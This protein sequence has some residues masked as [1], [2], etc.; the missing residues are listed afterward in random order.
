MDFEKRIQ[1]IYDSCRTTEQIEAAFGQLQAELESDIN[2]RIQK[3][4][5]LLLDN[6]DEDIHDL[7]KLQLDQAEQRLD[8]ISRWFWAVTRHQLKNTAEFD[9]SNHSFLLQ[10]NVVQETPTGQYQLIRRGQHQ[11]DALSNAHIYR[12]THPLGEWVLTSAKNQATPPAHITF[13][14]T[15]HGAKITVLES[16]LGKTGTLKCQRYSIEALER[17]E[18][19]LLFA[20]E[21]HEG[22]P[23]PVET[24]QKLMQLPAVTC[25][26]E[27]VQETPAIEQ[28]LTASQHELTKMVNSRNLAFFEE[29]VNKL[30]HWADDLKFGLE[31]S[32]KETDKEIKEVR[33]NAKI[34]PTLEEKLAWQKQ[35]RD[36]ERAR[37]K[38]RKE[39]FDR[40]DEVDE[41]REALIEQLEGKLN[42]TVQ[43]E[44]LFTIRWSLN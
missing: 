44:D 39:L 3:T 24:A 8:K 37:N 38:Q 6:F 20:A 13:N 31:Q 11:N 30:D 34:A 25:R 21:T 33:R 23:I 14:Y 22:K 19:H 32:I 15:A 2:A 9:D 16:L 12:L 26:P 10:Q 5:Q 41:R 42:Q 27:A 17:T 4:Q 1:T 40:Q 18:D 28:T 7:L 29:E 36:L 35:Q 43:I